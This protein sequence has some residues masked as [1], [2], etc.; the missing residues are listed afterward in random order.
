M[1]IRVDGKLLANNFNERAIQFI[2]SIINKY[3]D[4]EMKNYIKANVSNQYNLIVYKLS[5]S[6]FIA[7]LSKENEKVL[8]SKLKEVSFKYNDILQKLFGL[9]IESYKYSDKEQDIREYKFIKYIVLSKVDDIGPTSIAWLPENLEDQEKFEIS[10][11]SLLVLSA[12]FDPMVSKKMD[13]SSSII[14]FVKFGCIGLVFTFLI[15]SLKARGKSYDA[16]ITVLVPEIY[17]K[18]LLEK[19]DQ[20]EFEIKEVVKEI[21][22]G[23]NPRNLLMYLRSKLEKIMRERIT[24]PKVQS[25]DDTLK[26][27]MISE[28]RKIQEKKPYSTLLY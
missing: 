18:L 14:P 9:G 4:L 23:K 1:I 5:P 19:L 8:I 2:K 12:G 10:A 7:C 13:H 16:A 21:K 20:M 15:P 3:K 11:K 27:I 17:K 6:I 26:K 22:N 25:L 28:I 24:K